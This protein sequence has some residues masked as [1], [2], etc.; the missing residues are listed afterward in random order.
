MGAEQML[1]TLLHNLSDFV[2][3]I[4]KKI[5]P[6]I[7]KETIKRLLIWMGWVLMIVAEAFIESAE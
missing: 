6:V 4:L 7:R 5:L 1:R 2:E 3:Q